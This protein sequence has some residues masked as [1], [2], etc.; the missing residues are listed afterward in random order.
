[1]NKLTELDEA[2][3]NGGIYDEIGGT[4]GQLDIFVDIKKS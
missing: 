1:V 2:V 3:N 4:Q